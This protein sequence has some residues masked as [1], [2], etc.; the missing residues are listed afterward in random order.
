MC[1]GTSDQEQRRDAG[2]DLAVPALAPDVPRCEPLDCITEDGYHDAASVG[3]AR[4]VPPCQGSR[5]SGTITPLDDPRL[6][7]GVL[8]RCGA[9]RKLTGVD[10]ADSGR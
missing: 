4:S 9:Q 3:N 7:L 10:H 5:N 8:S 6:A 2:A 1:T